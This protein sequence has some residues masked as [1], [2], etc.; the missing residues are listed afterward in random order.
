MHFKPNTK[1]RYQLIAK[2][3]LGVRAKKIEE[4]EKADVLMKTI[5]VG[6]NGDIKESMSFR[7]IKFYDIINQEWEDSDW[8]QDL[9]RRMFF[10]VFKANMRGEYLLSR[11]KF[12]SIPTA[13]MRVLEKVW[14][15]TK[16]KISKGDFESFIKQSDKRLGHVRPKGKD[17]KDLM[18]APDGSVVLISGKGTD[19]YIMGPHNT[20]TPWSDAKVVQQEM[21][22]L[23]GEG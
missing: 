1:N 7:Q 18:E 16:E 21:S 3:I 15:D 14:I 12:F 13:D 20:K 22:A 23:F 6:N 5:R 11:V 4:F 10:V 9:N 19:P 2:A 8:Y 17:G